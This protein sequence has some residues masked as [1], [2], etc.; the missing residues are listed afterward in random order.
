MSHESLTVPK[1]PRIKERDFQKA[2]IDLA[3][4]LGWGGITR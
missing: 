2:V 4:A 3:S 1:P